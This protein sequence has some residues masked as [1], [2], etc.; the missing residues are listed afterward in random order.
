MSR[1]RV[2]LVEDEPH[3]ARG[4]AFNLEREGIEVVAVETGEAALEELRR[5][6]FALVILDVM[7]PGMDGL[8]V[9]R[10]I[11]KVDAR[12]PV[13]LLTALSEEEDRIAGLQ[14][15]ADDYLTKPFSLRE[16][17]LRV[18]GMLRRSTWYRPSARPGQPVRFGDNVVD[19]ERGE[20]RTPAG[21]VSLT[22]L[23]TRMLRTFL[24]HEGE[25]LSRAQLLRWVWGVS[26]DTET[27]T[28][29][30]FMVRLRKYFEPDPSRP[31]FFLTVRGKGY[32]FVGDG[33]PG[34]S[35]GA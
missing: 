2:L 35:E 7:L 8:R 3:I 13:L 10:A 14:E 17:L 9:C 16:L 26:P 25:V 29:D 22:E 34:A 24:D 23:E 33:E 6:P 18:Q 31:R 5:R 28:L 21:P 4:I 20:A 11:R 19:L 1:P 15:G 30:N 27:R 12:L 32:R